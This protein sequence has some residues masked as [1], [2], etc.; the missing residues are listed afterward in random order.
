[1]SKYLQELKGIR[2]GTWLVRVSGNWRVTFEFDGPDAISVNYE[3]VYLKEY[4]TGPTLEAGLS[5]YFHFYNYQRLHQ[6]LQYNA[7]A[8]VHFD[9]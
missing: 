1:M 7:P 4:A 3:A 8:E 5:N 9:C 2:Q 6:N